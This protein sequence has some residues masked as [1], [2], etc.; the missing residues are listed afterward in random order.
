MEQMTQP[1]LDELPVGDIVSNA[2]YI[3]EHEK[4]G[5][6]YISSTADVRSRRNDHMSRLRKGINRNGPLQAAFNENQN[7]SFTFIPTATREEAYDFE[8]KLINHYKGSEMLL[9]LATDVKAAGK[10][11]IRSEETRQKISEAGMGR[12]CKYK[13]QPVSEAHH[14]AIIASREKIRKQVSIN[15]TVYPSLTEAGNQLGHTHSCIIKRI[16]S[17]S[18]QFKDYFFL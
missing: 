13:G 17:Q 15:G 7:L 5:K 10:G 11:L 14:L 9:N 16:A 6:I 18:D 12:P 1:V 3:I 4:S 2:A 8:Q